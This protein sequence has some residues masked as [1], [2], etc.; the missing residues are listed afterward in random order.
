M[1]HL[2]SARALRLGWTFNWADTWF[3]VQKSDYSYF[4]FLCFRLRYFLLSYFYSKKRDKSSYI[5]S[6]FNII[7]IS[8]IIM[9]KIFFYDSI[10][11]ENKR[12]ILPKVLKF[13]NRSFDSY[14]FRN[15]FINNASMGILFDSE[16][17]KKNLNW[18]RFFLVI[19]KRLNISSNI[20]RSKYN[21]KLFRSFFKI[22]NNLIFIIL[23]Q[24]IRTSNINLDNS[25]L[26]KK[27]KFLQYCFMKLKLYFPVKSTNLVF[28]SNKYNNL[29]DAWIVLEYCLF[30]NC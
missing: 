3:A 23:I 14:L 20:K 11:E 15:R 1:G 6:H 16:L 24:F 25:L 19:K 2:V 26:F 5:Y 29:L 21:I 28:K 12:Y 4:L 8:R 7:K 10:F 27:S 30:K 9:I 13:V 18:L 22:F 17:T